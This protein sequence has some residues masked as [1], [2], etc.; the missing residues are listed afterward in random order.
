MLE[1]RLSNIGKQETFKI[2]NGYYDI[3]HLDSPN[4]LL[5]KAPEREDE[6]QTPKALYHKP[7]GI[8]IT[9]LASFPFLHQY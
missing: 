8:L 9:Y 2:L 6:H 5:N 3:E 1:I 7:S 4:W